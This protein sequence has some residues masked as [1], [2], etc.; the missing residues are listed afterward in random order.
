MLEWKSLVISNNY[1]SGKS[2]FKAVLAAEKEMI[3][4]PVIA[5]YETR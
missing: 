1:D 4:F 2:S 5:K 3:R